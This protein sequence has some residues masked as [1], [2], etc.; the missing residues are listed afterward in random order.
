MKTIEFAVYAAV[1]GLRGVTILYG[2]QIQAT[3]EFAGTAPSYRKPRQPKHIIVVG[4]WLLGVGRVW[5]A[6]GDKKG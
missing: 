3:G 5:L 4:T 1:D 6:C 2:P